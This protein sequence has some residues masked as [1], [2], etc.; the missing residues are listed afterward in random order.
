MP[1]KNPDDLK[2]QKREY[3]HANKERILAYHKE[4]YQRTRVEQIARAKKYREQ[5]PDYNRDARL[6]KLYGLTKTDYLA[7][8]AEQGG[9]C[10]ICGEPQEERG[11]NRAAVDHDHAT[12]AVRGLLCTKCNTGL[13]AFRDRT[14]LLAKAAMYLKRHAEKNSESA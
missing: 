10:A 1:Y 6:S 11:P 7:M 5:N 13:G 3:Y 14:D 2:A 4:R 9:G 8:L 12:G